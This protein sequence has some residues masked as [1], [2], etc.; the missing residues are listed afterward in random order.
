MLDLSIAFTND[1]INI[2]EVN[3]S[4]IAASELNPAVIGITND[5]IVSSD[6]IGDPRSLVFDTKA[7][8]KAGSN[9]VKVLGWYDNGHC[10]ATRILDIIRSYSKLKGF[11]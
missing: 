4:V 8:L 5:P 9:L 6:I 1:K 2:E 7:T 10:H 11:K 3:K